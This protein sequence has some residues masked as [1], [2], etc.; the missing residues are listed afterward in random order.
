MVAVILVVLL[1]IGFYFIEVYSKKYD[2]ESKHYRELSDFIGDKE[3]ET[4]KV[5]PTSVLRKYFK[6]HPDKLVSAEIAYKKH[7]ESEHRYRERKKKEIILNRIFAYDYE[8]MLYQ[9]YAKD[10]EEDIG[11]GKWFTLS[12]VKKEDIL[13]KISESKN[14]DAIE[15]NK[16]FDSLCEHDLLLNVC[17]R[18]SLTTLLQDIS[19]Q[20]ET[21]WNIVS[22]LDMNLDKW[23]VANGYE[24]KHIHLSQCR[25]M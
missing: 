14:V 18:Y 19:I 25:Q 22:D 21:R 12:T 1:C 16:I 17:G 9:L 5:Y 7:K 23:M 11:S 4:Y 15:A 10:A 3:F 20:G 8:E 24:H 13:Q 2:E 6:N